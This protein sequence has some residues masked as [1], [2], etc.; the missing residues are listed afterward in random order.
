MNIN[1][2]KVG[3]RV[4][5]FFTCKK[6]P[7]CKHETEG[8][9]KIIEP[10]D[11]RL[12][13]YIDGNLSIE[14]IAYSDIISKLE[15]LP[16]HWRTGDSVK[17]L[18]SG[19]LYRY[20]RIFDFEDFYTFKKDC[21]LVLFNGESTARPINIKNLEPVVPQY[22]EIKIEQ[23]QD[24]R[25]CKCCGQWVCK[26][27]AGVNL[28]NKS[29]IKISDLK[30]GDRI[31]SYNTGGQIQEGTIKTI[32]ENYFIFNE[33]GVYYTRP[34]LVICKLE[35]I[36]FI[37]FSMGTC[38]GQQN[39][40][41]CDTQSKFIGGGVCYRY[42]WRCD[43]CIKN[44]GEIKKE[45]KEIPIEKEENL[46]E[47]LKFFIEEY[48]KAEAKEMVNK[49]FEEEFTKNNKKED[50]KPTPKSFKFDFKVQSM[51]CWHNINKR[52]PSSK[53]TGFA[54]FNDGRIEEDLILPY[55]FDLGDITLGKTYAVE[56]KE[57]D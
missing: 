9:I 5:Y 40:D 51:E 38:N 31:K 42:P 53:M 49:L 18:W 11:G 13:F 22:K 19:N 27:Y 41:I 39:C 26:K 25:I 6:A 57:K 33:P 56:I 55:D 34:D 14:W 24:P 50:K 8:I 29:S 15:H 7:Y 2:L 37:P 54:K 17:V 12:D 44:H 16:N 48:A 1:E 36:K 3:D 45:Y 4:K 30:V 32:G 43:K 20:G 47:Y 10:H 35:P 52:K 23:N 28:E 46:P 21:Y